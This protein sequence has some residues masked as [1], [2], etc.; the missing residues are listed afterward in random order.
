MKC[1][2]PGLVNIEVSS[3]GNNLLPIFLKYRLSYHQYLWK[4]LT[5]RYRRYQ[6]ILTAVNTGEVKALN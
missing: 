5:M 1:L 2:A 6:Y 4:E 3:I